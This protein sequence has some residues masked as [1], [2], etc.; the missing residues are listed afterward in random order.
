MG[1]SDGG[2]MF[3]PVCFKLPVVVAISFRKVAREWW[4]GRVFV[5]AGAIVWTKVTMVLSSKGQKKSECRRRSKEKIRHSS[6]D[7]RKGNAPKCLGGE[8]DHAFAW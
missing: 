8:R 5:E 4:W 7:L 1:M 6:I 3:P 2:D